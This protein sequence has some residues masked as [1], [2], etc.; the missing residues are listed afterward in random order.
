MCFIKYHVSED[1]LSIVELAGG[2]G[3]LHCV[4]TYHEPACHF[5]AKFVNGKGH[6]MAN[7]QKAT[8]HGQFF[9]D[10]KLSIPLHLWHWYGA[11]L[12]QRDRGICFVED[13]KTMRL[14]GVAGKPTHIDILNFPTSYYNPCEKDWWNV[15]CVVY[16]TTLSKSSL[17]VNHGKVCD[18]ACCL[19]MKPSTLNLFNRVVHFDNVSGFNGYI[20]SVEMFNYIKTIPS[21]FSTPRM[22][23]LCEKYKI[24]EHVW[25]KVWL[26]NSIIDSRPDNGCMIMQILDLCLEGILLIPSP[27]LIAARIKYI[28]KK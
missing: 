25:Y 1:R 15:V 9:T 22:T 2:V 20:G 14:H 24:L 26:M 7:V 19:P 11:Q 16:D 27:D 23:Y 21:G 3:T 12:P 18:C 13:E 4:S 10:E 8:S 6:K 28:C 5:D 17:W